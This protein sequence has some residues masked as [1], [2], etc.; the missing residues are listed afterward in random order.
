ML[1]RL[2]KM[3]LQPDDVKSS[4]VSFNKETVLSGKKKSVSTLRAYR[5]IKKDR[6]KS[7]EKYFQ[8]G[9][10][11]DLLQINRSK[12]RFWEQ[13]GLLQLERDDDNHYRQYTFSDLL[14]I[15]DIIFYRNLHFS[16]DELRHV[17]Q[18]SACELEQE[19]ENKQREIELE[20][21][22]LQQTR[23]EIVNRRRYLQEAARLQQFPDLPGIPDFQR[24]RL[25]QRDNPADWQRS[26]F[27]QYVFIGVQQH[28]QGDMLYGLETDDAQVPC[29]WQQQPGK[30]YVEV[31]LQYEM[32][33]PGNNNV[34]QHCRRL[35]QN[36]WQSGAIVSRFLFSARGEDGRNYD[37]H[38]GW[39]E[40]RR[41]TG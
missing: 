25:F 38:K 13:Q 3:K 18:H 33:N 11:A 37:Y 19:L 35:Q 15:T 2:L 32:Q 30:Q 12:L 1:L 31:L 10:I 14:R 20:L 27:N 34:A 41:P 22:A 26:L 28:A 6:I 23:Q 9:E 7:M 4:K 39:I 24:V 5:F 21:A 36:G 40:V 8:I 16:T 29:I 17:L